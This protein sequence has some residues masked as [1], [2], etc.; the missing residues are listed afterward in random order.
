MRWQCFVSSSW[1]KGQK[2]EEVGE[3]IS[4]WVNDSAHPS[5]LFLA[6]QETVE[7]DELHSLQHDDGIEEDP[8]GSAVGTGNLQ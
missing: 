3:W 6:L 4:P 1:R 2:V 7:E 5:L 8:L